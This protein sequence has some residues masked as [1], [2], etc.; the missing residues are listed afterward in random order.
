L[1]PKGV[2]RARWFFTITLCVKSKFNASFKDIPDENFN[3]VLN[4]I[5]FLK[6][7]PS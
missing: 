7:N 2:E 1:G 5:N 6:E 4:Y 3:E